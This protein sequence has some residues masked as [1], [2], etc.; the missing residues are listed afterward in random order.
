MSSVKAK[1]KKQIKKADSAKIEES[2]G[3]IEKGVSSSK[4]RNCSPIN[5]ED[6]EE[7]VERDE[8]LPADPLAETNE[9]DAELEEIG[10]DDE[11]LDPFHDK[12][13]Q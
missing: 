5:I 12:W 3:D 1:Q 13:E 7:I 2:V 4:N 10:L 6:V 11:E 8:K 9:I